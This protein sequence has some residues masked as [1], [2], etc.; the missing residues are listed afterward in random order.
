M[1]VTFPITKPIFAK[2]VPISL[3]IG[4]DGYY[5]DNIFLNASGVSDYVSRIFTDINL[6]LNRLNFSINASADFFAENSD[7]NAIEISPGIQYFQPLKKRDVLFLGLNFDVVNYHE[8]YTDFNYSGPQ[9]YAG[10]KLYTGPR[11]LFK[12][13]YRFQ[14]RNYHNYSSFDFHNHKGFI[15]YRKFF[16]SQTTVVLQ[17]GFNYRYYPHIATE[18]DFG[19]GYDYFNNKGNHGG[20]GMGGGPGS[21]GGGTGSGNGSGPGSGTGNMPPG[22]GGNTLLSQEVDVPNIFAILKLNQAIGTTLGISGEM[23]WRNQF[24]ELKYNETEMLIKNAYVLFPYNDDF[25]WDGLRFSVQLKAIIFS[26][27]AV[28]GEISYYNKYYPGINILDQE[29]NVMEPVTERKDKVWIYRLAL[30]KKLNTL[31]LFASVT[32]RHNDSN[33]DYFLYNM[34]AVSAGLSFDF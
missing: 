9:L 24:K 27:I 2:T 32:Y 25:L 3:G 20:G 17:T 14:V 26:G 1:L 18:Y 22:T 31:N 29:G 30:A 11:S 8:R 23:E 6:P 28:E 19:K 12:A 16:K 4:I 10:I 21:G 13:E 34:L 7:F 5:S 15:Q 33:D